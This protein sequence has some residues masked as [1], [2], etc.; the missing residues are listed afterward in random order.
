VR[1]LNCP[2]S[3]KIHDRKQGPYL[4]DLRDRPPKCSRQNFLIIFSIFL[5][6][7]S[8]QYCYHFKQKYCIFFT[9]KAFCDAQKVLTR[10][11]RPGI[12]PDPDGELMTLLRPPSRLGGDTPHNPQ[13][14]RRLWRLAIG[15]S[16][17]GTPPKFFS[18]YG[19]DQK[20]LSIE[21]EYICRQTPGCNYCLPA[22]TGYQ[23]FCLFFFAS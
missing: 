19:S 5:Q 20:C 16:F 17:Q 1:G 22:A 10:R 23:P 4:R 15:V 12:R 3:A 18:A 13:L 7:C 2:A 21:F 9:S 8:C 11:L 6:C 14:L